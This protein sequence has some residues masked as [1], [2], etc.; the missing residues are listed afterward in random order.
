[1]AENADCVIKVVSRDAGEPST[2]RGEAPR[3]LRQYAGGH[4]SA[5]GN[6]GAGSESERSTAA[7]RETKLVGSGLRKTGFGVGGNH[8]DA[9]PFE[10]GRTAHGKSCCRRVAGARQRA[11]VADAGVEL[12]RQCGEIF[13]CKKR[14]RGGDKDADARYDIAERA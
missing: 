7:K 12:V 13:R 3:V 4:G 8:T 5:A 1:R 9:A 2:R 11:R 14:H 10:A 6:C